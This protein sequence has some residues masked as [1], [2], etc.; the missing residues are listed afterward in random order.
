V[1][2]L[3]FVVL[4]ALGSY[5][6]L[7]AAV[8]SRSRLRRAIL[9]LVAAVL[10]SMQASLAL[11]ASVGGDDRTQV[12]PFVFSIL[13]ALSALASIVLMFLKPSQQPTGSYVRKEYP[14]A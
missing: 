2:A 4:A 6:I 9:A 5:A 14:D 8:K 3:I 10:L 11:L 1:G 13:Y 7:W 12:M